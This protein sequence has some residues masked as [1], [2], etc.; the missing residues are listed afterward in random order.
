MAATASTVANIMIGNDGEAV[1]VAALVSL[2]QP[3]PDSE[4]SFDRRTYGEF[5]KDLDEEDIM[6]S[7]PSERNDDEGEGNSESEE[8][9]LME[10]QYGNEDDSNLVSYSIYVINIFLTACIRS[11]RFGTPR[12]KR[13]EVNIPFEVPYKNDTRDL[14]GIASLTRTKIFRFFY[15]YSKLFSKL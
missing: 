2:G 6:D 8:D 4:S 1:A 5:F 13:Q 12:K 10:T 7:E 14:T 11:P 9:Q 3:G 15:Y